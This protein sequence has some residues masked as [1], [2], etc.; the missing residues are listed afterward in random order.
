MADDFNVYGG[1]FDFLKHFL[2]NLMIGLSVLIFIKWKFVESQTYL[3]CLNVLPY[4][5]IYINLYIASM[6]CKFTFDMSIVFFR[7]KTATILKK[8]KFIYFSSNEIFVF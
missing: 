2:K 8:K 4:W 5:Y 6:I 1:I 3:M 7:N